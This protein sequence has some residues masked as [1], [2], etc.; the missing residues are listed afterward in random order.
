[1]SGE[2]LNVADGGRLETSDGAGSFL[3]NYGDGLYANEVVLSDFEPTVPE[4]TGL[5]AMGLGLLGLI[6]RRRKNLS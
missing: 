3:V 1:M 5:G 4:P 2:F 6:R